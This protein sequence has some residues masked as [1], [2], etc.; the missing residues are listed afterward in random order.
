MEQS[1]NAILFYGYCWEE[2]MEYP[3]DDSEADEQDNETDWEER[4]AIAK[5]LGPYPLDKSDKEKRA[6]W[7][8]QKKLVEISGCVVG[9]HCHHDASMPYVAI[10][11]SEVEAHRGYPEGVNDN[12][13]TI[14]AGWKTQLDTFCAVM[15]I[16]T[17]QDKPRWWLVSY[18]G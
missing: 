14:N 11:A 5:G 2:E 6:Y 9:S 12:H 8:A 10:K 18:W 15:G 7:D 16:T 17:P 3:W 4:Y 1:T 13:L